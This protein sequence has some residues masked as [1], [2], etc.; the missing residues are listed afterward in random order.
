MAQ[1]V[2]SLPKGTVLNGYRL[3]RVLGQGGFGIVYKA[4]RLADGA[5]V[6]VKENIPGTAAIRE[7]GNIAF[8]VPPDDDTD[9]KGGAAWARQNFENETRSLR[10]LSHPGVVQVLDSFASPKTNTEYYVMT[11]IAGGLLYDLARQ[12]GERSREWVL[13][14]AAALINSA[15]YI[16]DSGLF[17]RDLKPENVMVQE[18]GEPVLIDFGAARKADATYKT[19]V[20]TPDYSSIEQSEGGKEGPW[21]DVYS[22]GGTLY[23]VIT[24]EAPPSAKDRDGKVTDPYVPLA[25][26]PEL[27]E[28]YGRE[29]LESVDKALSTE[30]HK[31]FPT[32]AHW[33]AALY[34]VPGFQGVSPVLRFPRMRNDGEIEAK[35]MA[36]MYA[37]QNEKKKRMLLGCILAAGVLLLALL[38][39]LLLRFCQPQ[40]VPR[41]DLSIVLPPPEKMVQSIP[42]EMPDIRLIGRTEACL[43]DMAGNVIDKNLPPF[44]VY[45]TK[46]AEEMELDGRNQLAYVVRTHPLEKPIG[47]LRAEDVYPWPLNLSMRFTRDPYRERALFFNAEEKAGEFM[48]LDT[49]GRQKLRD[50][51]ASRSTA[52]VTADQR[53]ADNQQLTEAGVVGIEPKQRGTYMMPVLDFAKDNEGFPK[54]LTY[55]GTQ[56]NRVGLVKVASMTTKLKE[57]AVAIPPPTINVVFVVDTTSSMSHYLDEIRKRISEE[58][59][60][61]ARLGAEKKLNVLFGFVGYRD[62][63]SE[64]KDG[65]P[66]SADGGKMGDAAFAQK[67][68]YVVNN[69]TKDRLLT[70]PEFQELL[71]KKLDAGTYSI[72][73]SDEDSIDYREEVYGAVQSAID[74]TPWSDV[75]D[76]WQKENKRDFRFIWLVGDAG[77]RE[78]GERES[79]ELRL[80]NSPYWDYRPTGSFV[81]MNA[82]DLLLS[83]LEAKRVRLRSVF[84]LTMP[85][86]GSMRK[87]LTPDE[88]LRYSQRPGIEQ[89]AELSKLNGRVNCDVL[90]PH[91]VESKLQRM[92]M[93]DDY[94]ASLKKVVS[95]AGARYKEDSFSNLLLSDFK[96]LMRYTKEAA[97]FTVNTKEMPGESAIGRLFATSYVEWREA[98][99]ADGKERKDAVGWLQDRGE[100]ISTETLR[101]CVVLSAG[102][103]NTMIQQL[104]NILRVMKDDSLVSAAADDVFEEEGSVAS[105]SDSVASAFTA[106]Q[107][108]GAQLQQTEGQQA[109]KD[110]NALS[111][112]A[113]QELKEQIMKLP[114]TSPLLKKVAAG[115]APDKA[116]LINDLSSTLQALKGYLHDRSN[117]NVWMLDPKGNKDYDYVTIP[118]DALL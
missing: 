17:H 45:Y 52:V 115:N 25:S 2:A 61:A 102:Q 44:R 107:Y 31:R 7:A 63:K 57:K 26:R 36:G 112:K 27:V 100:K 82:R 89:F 85:V 72:S 38:V 95:D 76:V 69:Y 86:Q 109:N 11:Y 93:T 110:G 8:E 41:S 80:W 66:E 68:G 46:K 117:S 22:L 94:L 101:P 53:R 12:P 28:Q 83:K 88:W 5:V 73:C 60:N 56:N 116:K 13:Y 50:M 40:E 91:G 114:Y 42:V 67:I 106:V 81:G 23:F 84:V 18:S 54:N 79:D 3:E 19:T 64:R 35:G 74:E 34:G 98:Q 6:V 96:D 51:M 21:S 92:E 43:Y 71:N 1:L 58:A 39:L 78:V 48:V 24:G 4:V 30:P 15:S 16:H 62:W 108:D 105:F 111:R 32:M 103:L 29:F 37:P 49:H 14:I 33:K 55:R 65:S 113:Q 10:R 9:A 97:D 99:V 20:V 87:S 77:G 70:L 47:V 90:L 75:D 104:E 59:E 118:V